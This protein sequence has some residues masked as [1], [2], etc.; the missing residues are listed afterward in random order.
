MWLVLKQQILRKWRHQE[1]HLTTFVLQ[2]TL[3]G[4]ER[5]REEPLVG[6]GLRRRRKAGGLELMSSDLARMSR[7]RVE[8]PSEGWSPSD[9]ISSRPKATVILKSDCIVASLDALIKN[10]AKCVGFNL[11]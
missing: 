8:T 2:Y 1:I 4:W 6:F 5:Q 7:L 10:Q 9:N 11:I 3:D